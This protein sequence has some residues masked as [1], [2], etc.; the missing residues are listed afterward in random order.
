MKHFLICNNC[1]NLNELKSEYMVF[2]TFCGKKMANNFT[3]WQRRNP[4]KTFDDYRLSVG[5]AE[6][7]LPPENP[8]KKN[9]SKSR[10]LKQKITI[11]VVAV[12]AATIGTIIGDKIID[13]YRNKNKKDKTEVLNQEWTKKTY[14]TNG[15]TL[16]IPWELSKMPIQSQ[17]TELKEYVEYFEMYQNSDKES[18]K[19]VLSSARYKPE[20]VVNLQGAADGTIYGL[21]SQENV[22]DFIYDEKPYLLD[23][24][25][26]YIQTGTFKLKGEPVEFTILGFNYKQDYKQ[27][28]V[29]VKKDDSDAKKIAERII[30]SIQLNWN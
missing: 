3:E 28:V 10:S 19:V 5:V 11:V 21:K 9:K 30:K 4:G 13:S 6:D 27:I 17:M 16:E 8:H 29:S 2:C 7:Q 15:I 12:L 18:V 22:S 1:G 14:G 24:I 23:S 26:G 25:P 20:V